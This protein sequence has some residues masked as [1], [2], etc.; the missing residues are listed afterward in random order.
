MFQG[1]YRFLVVCFAAV[2]SASLMAYPALMGYSGLS[3]LPDAGMAD[4]Q[5][6]S[7]ALDTQDNS[8]GITK[9]W[10]LVYGI[11]DRLEAGVAFVDTS[12]ETFAGTLKYQFDQREEQNTSLGLLAASTSEITIQLTPPVNSVQDAPETRYATPPSMTLPTTKSYQLYLVH[13]RLISKENENYPSLIGTV[14]VNWTAMA[15]RGID[16]QAVR[17]FLGAEADFK[18]MVLLADYQFADDEMDHKP[19]FS[20]AAR[21]RLDDKI[22]VQFG[23]SNALGVLG[24]NTKRV[25]MGATYQFS[26]R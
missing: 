22:K 24:G 19:M 2:W 10:R 17:P 11:T 5:S 20:I 25:F 8:S 4:Q 16:M 9:S 14:G 12:R 23:Y 15:A 7:V 13:S 21:Y 6:I 1:Y 3:N 26:P 18:R